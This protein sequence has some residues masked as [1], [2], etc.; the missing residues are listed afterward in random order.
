M[1]ERRIAALLD[2]LHKELE[3]YN[4]KPSISINLHGSTYE[5]KLLNEEQAKEICQKLSSPFIGAF[6]NL[7]FS[8][9]SC[10]NTDWFRMIAGDIEVAVFY[11][12]DL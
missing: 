9:N 5:D 1:K 10:N 6:D 3:Y 12:N 11:R 4:A 8:K 7:K 2:N